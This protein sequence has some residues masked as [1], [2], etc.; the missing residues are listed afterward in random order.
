M[1]RRRK[2]ITIVGLVILSALYVFEMDKLINPIKDILIANGILDKKVSRQ[3]V[4]DNTLIATAKSLYT[5]P[6]P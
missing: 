3:N 5:A 4:L 2:Y 6:D 1:T